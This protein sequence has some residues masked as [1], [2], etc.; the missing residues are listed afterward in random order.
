MIVT[1]VVAA[2]WCV[3]L[4]HSWRK[5]NPFVISREAEKGSSS[6]TDAPLL[7]QRVINRRILLHSVARAGDVTSAGWMEFGGS[8][9]R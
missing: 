8:K 6:R 1:V 5:S 3:Y 9:P 4:V 2:T 7:L